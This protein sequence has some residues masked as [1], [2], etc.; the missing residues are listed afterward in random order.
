MSNKSSD[1]SSEDLAA[2]L[3]EMGP[4][5]GEPARNP[6]ADAVVARLMQERA[7]IRNA[8][9]LEGIGVRELAKRLKVSPAA[10]SRQLKDGKDMYIGTATILAHALGREFTIDLVRS[11]HVPDTMTN[12]RTAPIVSP[13]LPTVRAVLDVDPKPSSNTNYTMIRI[14]AAPARPAGRAT[15]SAADL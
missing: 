13:P 1:L 14:D 4:P 5:A 3:A 8:M 11:R 9:A 10:V 6:E 2:I 7:L 15:I 12:Y